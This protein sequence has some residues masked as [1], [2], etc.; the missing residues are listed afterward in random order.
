[1]AHTPGPWGVPDWHQLGRIDVVDSGGRIVAAVYL[2]DALGEEAANARLIAASPEIL[3]ALEHILTNRDD[4][5]GGS[6]IWCFRTFEEEDQTLCTSD[7]CDGFIARA[8]IAK[9]RGRSHQ[10]DERF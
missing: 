2:R 9:A 6:C 10:V 7:D 8:A 4:I 1:M 3:A 5:G